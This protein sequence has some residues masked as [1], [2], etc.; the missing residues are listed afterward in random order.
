MN[1]PSSH[2]VL[3]GISQGRTVS[4]GI[5]M[6]LVMLYHLQILPFAYFGNWGVDVFFF[7]SGWG[8]FLSLTKKGRTVTQFYIR[9]LVR[10]MPPCILA[11]TS[12]ALAN[13]FFNDIA[14]HDFKLPH[15]LDSALWALGLH[16]WYIR[17][18]LILYL[19]SPLFVFLVSSRNIGRHMIILICMAIVMA[20][21]APIIKSTVLPSDWT[22]FAHTTI[23]WTLYR[24]P[25]F[26]AG[27]IVAFKPPVISRK[28]VAWALFFLACAIFVNTS[29]HCGVL[30]KSSSPLQF[31]LLLPSLP[32]F[33]LICG[34]LKRGRAFFEYIGTRSLELYVVHEAIFHIMFKLY[35]Q[36]AWTTA[37]SVFLAFILAEMLWKL[38]NRT[39]NRELPTQDSCLSKFKD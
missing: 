15:G 37:G 18:L 11:G 27:M 36:T 24:A 21:S 26:I 3:Q 1:A 10:I 31:L 29:I 28:L 4:M 6:A 5:A 19:L 33:C 25:A 23:F 32:L 9:R 12:I 7:L 17:S 20:A 16:L 34:K 30:A 14:I 35:G 38:T 2:N 13:V 22:R 39:Q 8:I